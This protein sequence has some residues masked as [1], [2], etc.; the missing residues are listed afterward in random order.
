M[1]LHGRLRNFGLKVGTRSRSRFD[2]RIRELAA[3]N[4]MP[5]AATDPAR[6]AL[7][8]KLAGPERQLTQ[9]DAACRRFMSMPELGAV[10]VLTCRSAVNDPT[11][12]TSSK[13]VRP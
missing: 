3:G 8:Q 10:A 12:F 6:V 11:S 1:P 9:D 5:E 13:N 7:R 2:Q 4:L